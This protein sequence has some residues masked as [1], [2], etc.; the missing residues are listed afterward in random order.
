MNKEYLS[1]LIALQSAQLDASYAFGAYSD[2]EEKYDIK[3]SKL[4]RD[5]HEKLK[6][7]KEKEQEDFEEKCPGAIN[8][9]KLFI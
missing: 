7:F 5:Y 3:I 8:K 6:S 2:Q 1:K 4:T 9:S